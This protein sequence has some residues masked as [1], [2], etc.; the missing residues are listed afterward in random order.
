MKILYAISGLQLAIVIF[1]VSK[2]LTIEA[3]VKTLNSQVSSISPTNE[4]KHSNNEEPLI[5]DEAYQLE[6]SSIT[7]D[8]QPPLKVEIDYRQMRQ[9]IR[10]EVSSVIASAATAKPKTDPNSH[11]ADNQPLV[12]EVESRLNDYLTDGVLSQAEMANVENELRYLNFK[13]RQKILRKMAQAMN[14][15]NA[16]FSN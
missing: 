7:S 10:E 5:R 1:L 4:D 13:D 15:V 11:I 9:V 14:E 8:S 16:R 12:D 2:L 6:E 3:E